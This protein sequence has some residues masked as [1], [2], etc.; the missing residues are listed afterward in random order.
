VK[1]KISRKARP[2]VTRISDGI[3]FDKWVSVTG[4]LEARAEGSQR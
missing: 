3:F 4:A 2:S 1:T